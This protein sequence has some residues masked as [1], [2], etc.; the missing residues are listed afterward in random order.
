MLWQPHCAQPQSL[1]KQ[2]LCSWLPL[3]WRISTALSPLLNRCRAAAQAKVHLCLQVSS[4]SS[5]YPEVSF[6][7]AGVRRFLALHPGLSLSQQ[8][9]L[10]SDNQRLRRISLMQPERLHSRGKD[11]SPHAGR[12]RLYSSLSQAPL[13]PWQASS[14]H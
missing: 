8:Q 2:A 12:L 13:Q 10:H 9:R 7:R 5:Q 4:S 6:L 11:I 1:Q 3:L 14:A